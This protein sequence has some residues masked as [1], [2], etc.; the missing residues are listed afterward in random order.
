MKKQAYV[1]KKYECVYSEASTFRS[2][3]DEVYGLLTDY[4]V[5][6][7]TSDEHSNYCDWEIHCDTDAFEKCIEELKKMPPEE[8]NEYFTENSSHM[9][10][11]NQYVVKVFEEWLRCKDEK[12]K[13]IR[14]H[15]FD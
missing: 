11:T 5:G 10:I 7:W 14:V 1:V 2:L 4:D 6:I 3:A 15:W 8:V 12:D 13:V 9:G